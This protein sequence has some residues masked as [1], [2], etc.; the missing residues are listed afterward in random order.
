M[1]EFYKHL[2]LDILNLFM[3]LF[4]KHI[5]CFLNFSIEYLEHKVILM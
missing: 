4:L 2:K 5:M 3:G 1:K